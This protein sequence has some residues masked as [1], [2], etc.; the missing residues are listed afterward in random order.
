LWNLDTGELGTYNTKET[1]VALNDT[2]R[3]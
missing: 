1:M 2:H 3:K